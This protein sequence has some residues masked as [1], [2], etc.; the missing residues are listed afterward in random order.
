[1]SCAGCWFSVCHRHVMCGNELNPPWSRCCFPLCSGSACGS[2]SCAHPSSSYFFG[3]TSGWWHKMIST[4]SIGEWGIPSSGHT[5]VLWYIPLEG[6]SG[7]RGK[8]PSWACSVGHTFWSSTQVHLQPL[9]RVDGWNTP[10]SLVHHCGVQLCHLFDGNFESPHVLKGA[11]CLEFTDLP[12]FKILALFH[13]S[14]G[15]QLNLVWL[16]KVLIH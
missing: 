10:H 3:C 1:M 16:H 2:S 14:L 13:L 12:L 4:S 5:M 11:Y 6:Q 9:W 8:Q 15:Q 7:Y